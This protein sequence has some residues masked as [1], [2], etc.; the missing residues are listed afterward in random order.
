[1]KYGG[2]AI[3]YSTRRVK[4]GLKL[5]EELVDATLGNFSITEYFLKIKKL[6][7]EIFLLNTEEAISETN[8]KNVTPQT[9][10]EL[11]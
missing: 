9:F 2:P 4:L 7:F 8:G 10:R 6:C 11:N 5:E 3:D 1:M